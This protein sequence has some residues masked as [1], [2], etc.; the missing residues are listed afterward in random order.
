ML[1][2]LSLYL[3]GINILGYSLMGIDKWKAKRN[4]WRIQEQRFFLI[5]IF[6]GAIGVLLGMKHFRHKTLHKQF[7]YGIPAIL[8]VQ[9]LIVAF[10]IFS[11]YLRG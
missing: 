11:T 10:L 5:A 4:K 1:K 3:L 7:V 6:G 8:I 2:V 9:V